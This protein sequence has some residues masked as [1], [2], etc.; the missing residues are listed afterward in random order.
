VAWKALKPFAQVRRRTAAASRN[1]HGA[2]GVEAAG[3]AGGDNTLQL[4]AVLAGHIPVRHRHLHSSVRKVF[5]YRQPG[6]RGGV[7]AS[8]NVYSELHWAGLNCT[9]VRAPP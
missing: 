7:R 3:A 6:R 9:A 1:A 5:M 2:E 8:D 4:R